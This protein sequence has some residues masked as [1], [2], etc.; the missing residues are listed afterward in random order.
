[1]KGK[2]PQAFYSPL[3]LLGFAVAGI[4]FGLI[5]FL[6]TLEFFAH[7]TKPYM[8]IIA[9]IILPAIMICG[10]L[11]VA[12]ALWRE[13][14]LKKRGLAKERRMPVVDLNDPKHRTAVSMIT[15]VTVLLL[16]F[17][18][19]GSFKA[20][21][22]TDSD[23]FCGTMCHEVMHPEYTAYLNSAHSRVGC[24]KCHI[25]PGADWFVQSKISGAYQLYSV[26][27]NKYSRPI[28][29]PIKNLRPAQHT[30]EQCHWP[31]HFFSEKKVSGNYYLTDE[32]NTLHS[33]TMLMKVGG[34]TATSGTSN[35]IHYH[36]NI[37]NDIFYYT[38]D[39]SRQSIPW[40]K[41]IDKEGKEVVYTTKEKA[42]FTPPDKELRRFDCIDCHNRPAHIYNQPDK[43]LNRYMSSGR[44]DPQLP[45]IKSIAMDVLE[46][47]YYTTE[48]AVK[49]ID[50]YI[51]NFYSASYPD[52]MK[53][54][55]AD[56]AKTIKAIQE[57]Y[58]NNYF[59]TMK[60]SWKKYPNN[61]G[62]MYYEGCF[63]CH[64]DKHTSADG[65]KISSDCNVCHTI[66]GQ[67][68]ANEK[69]MVSL[70]GMDFIHPSN[71]NQGIE[72]NQCPDCHGVY[73]KN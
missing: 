10:L 17:S 11:L 33:L 42:G 44:I 62:H 39:E 57:I 6:M 12:V 9:F 64:D 69:E 31:A 28:E 58:S 2:L 32:S 24:A 14:S 54:R 67:K 38:D 53:T 7:E 3:A 50:L 21:E 65:R 22:Y 60:V 19:F 35:G 15:V 23:E 59:P 34:G 43:M 45:Y 48:E 55:Q 41:V 72:Y 5:L 51:S 68:I 63:R 40:I 27:F 66:I 25:G 52:V 61:L 36:M 29:T 20:Y 70:D 1:M 16:V 26:A 73:Q 49:K 8:G 37:A 47:D 13:H 46:K 18:A 71:L 30:C 4:S 56:L